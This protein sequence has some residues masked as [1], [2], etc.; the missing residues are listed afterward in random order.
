M[1]FE[2]HRSSSTYLEAENSVCQYFGIL[3]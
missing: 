3:L 1:K 2:R